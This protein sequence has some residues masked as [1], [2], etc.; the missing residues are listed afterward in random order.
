VASC[1]GVL[2]F[3]FFFTTTPFKALFKSFLA[4][5]F[6][7]AAAESVGWTG[8]SPVTAGGT[9]AALVRAATA[10]WSE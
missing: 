10:L 9:L 2:V 1:F 5:G 8:E 3:G 7:F 6:G 4:A